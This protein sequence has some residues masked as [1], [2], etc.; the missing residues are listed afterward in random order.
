M[1]ASNRFMDQEKFNIALPSAL[2]KEFDAV[3]LVYG[4]RKKGPMLSAAVLLLLELPPAARDYLVEELGVAKVR[5]DYNELITL[6]KRGELRQAALNRAR[7][8]PGGGGRI[9]STERQDNQEEATPP[10]NTRTK[11]PRGGKKLGRI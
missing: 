1:Y 7:A 3:S 8:I 10:E 4:K 2:K 5:S 6:A 9:A 11:Q